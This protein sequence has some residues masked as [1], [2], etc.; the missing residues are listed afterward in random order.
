GV[1][2]LDT[3]GYESMWAPVW[4]DTPRPDARNVLVWALGGTQDAQ[5]GF[6][7][8]DDLNGNGYGDAGEL[9]LVQS[10]TRSDIDFVIHVN[11]A[12]SSLWIVRS[13]E[14]RVGKEGRSWWAG[15]DGREKY[16]D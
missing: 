10:G 13:E 4:L 16:I 7:F 12:D 14:R 6:R 9:G 8:W 3:L 5:S 15:D 1:S 11:A 2:A